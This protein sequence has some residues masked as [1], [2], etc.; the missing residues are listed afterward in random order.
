MCIIDQNTFYRIPYLEWEKF[1]VPNGVNIDDLRK[2]SYAAH[3]WRQN[4]INKNEL[5]PK[6]SFIGQAMERYW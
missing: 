3:L 1:V 6:T 2:T 4:G 5:F